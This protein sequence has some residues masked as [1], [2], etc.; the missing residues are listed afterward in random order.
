M[1]TSLSPGE[2]IPLLHIVDAGEFGLSVS[3]PHY[4]IGLRRFVRNTRQNRPS[5]AVNV[6]YILVTQM[7]SESVTNLSSPLRPT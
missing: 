2:W 1:A 7:I 6:T 3:D 4:C 5:K